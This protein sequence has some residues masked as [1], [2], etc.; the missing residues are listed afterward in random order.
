M[1]KFQ[2][3]IEHYSQTAHIIAISNSSVIALI[4]QPSGL[5]TLVVRW[6]YVPSPLDHV[7]I[8]ECEGEKQYQLSDLTEIRYFPNTNR[9]EVTGTLSES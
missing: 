1:K 8:Y 6:G 2:A 7:R 4:D 9:L 3:K 5:Y